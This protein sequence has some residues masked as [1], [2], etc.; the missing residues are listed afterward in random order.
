MA[1]RRAPPRPPPPAAAAFAASASAAAAS[2]GVGCVANFSRWTLLNPHSFN[3]PAAQSPAARNCGE[4]VRRG[5][6]RSVKLYIVSIIG[7][8]V[9]APPRPPPPPA[10][11]AFPPASA[12]LIL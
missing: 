1:A 6:Y 2:A 5:P 3:W 12:A 9:A 10:P 11:P 7:T 4:L 8:G